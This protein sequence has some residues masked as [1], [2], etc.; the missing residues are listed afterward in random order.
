MRMILRELHVGERGPPL[1]FGEASL[2]CLTQPTV[3][4]DVV[5]S[6]RRPS[7]LCHKTRVH[8]RLHSDHLSI[9]T[10]TPASTRSVDHWH[11]P[12]ELWRLS[13]VRSYRLG[14]IHVI[15]EHSIQ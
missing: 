4:G 8:E 3:C 5:Y 13:E 15:C 12:M 10:M 14:E 6:S 2:G 7:P 9:A 11:C 1:I